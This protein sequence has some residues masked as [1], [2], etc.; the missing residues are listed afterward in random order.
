MSAKHKRGNTIP[1]DDLLPNTMAIMV[2]LNMSTPF[3][4]PF[5]RP[6]IKDARSMHNHSVGEK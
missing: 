3:I 4:P 1:V 5:V 6:I 2:T